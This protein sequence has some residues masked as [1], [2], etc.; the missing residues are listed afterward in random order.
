M[1]TAIA[2]RSS[3]ALCFLQN[4]WS[5]VYAGRTWPRASWLRALWASRSGQRLKV[6][7]E[8]APDIEFVFTN[9]TPICGAEPSS[10][11]EPDREHIQRMLRAEASFMAAEP[12]C[13]IA[14]GSQAARELAGESPLMILPHP[15]WRLLQNDTFREAGKILSAGFTG[16]VTLTSH[17]RESL[18][19]A[20]L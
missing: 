16:T 14:F 19:T 8:A 4:A 12:D 6:L 13:I 20:R 15:A 2:S 1:A 7:L 9:T 18:R 17:R 3:V 11:L 5:P 10:L